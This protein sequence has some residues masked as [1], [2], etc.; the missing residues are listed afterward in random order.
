MHCTRSS[1]KTYLVYW[2]T[3]HLCS[4]DWGVHLPAIYMHCTRSSSG[5]SSMQGIYA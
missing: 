4:I 1:S 2:Y 3:R 5:C